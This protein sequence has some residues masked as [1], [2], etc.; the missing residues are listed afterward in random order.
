MV[1]A[2]ARVDFPETTR[3]ALT[4]GFLGGLTTYS[5]FN[6]DTLS[7]LDRKLYGTAAVYVVVT[8]VVCLEASAIRR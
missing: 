8:L 5:S 6:K 4:A 1:Y 2:T 3:I 7:M